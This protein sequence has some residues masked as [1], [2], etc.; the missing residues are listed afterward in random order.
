MPDVETASQPLGADQAASATDVVTGAVDAAADD[1]QTGIG[2]TEAT[3]Q[4]TASDAADAAAATVSAAT[5]AAAGLATPAT[6][7]V[8][9]TLPQRSGAGANTLATGVAALRGAAEAL[10]GPGLAALGLELT[11]ARRA[12]RDEP[13]Q[14]LGRHALT[15]ATACANAASL[16]REGFCM[17]LTFRTY[18]SAAAST[19]SCVVGGL[20]VVEDADVPAH[21]HIVAA[22]P[23]RAAGQASSCSHRSTRTQSIWIAN[24][25]VGWL[26]GTIVVLSAA[27]TLGRSG[28]RLPPSSAGAFASRS[29]PQS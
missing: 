27:A 8:A 1:L 2:S 17:P 11:V 18:C 19:S 5:T 9:T 4:A 14:Q 3:A 23:R 15:S 22:V 28:S 13:V 25:R 16:A 24:H 6:G 7:A 26:S 12:G 20:E 29:R 10:R 21:G